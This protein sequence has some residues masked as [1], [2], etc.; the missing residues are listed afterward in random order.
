MDILSPLAYDWFRS[1]HRTKYKLVEGKT[2]MRRKLLILRERGF[3]FFC[4]VAK[5]VAH[6]PETA[7]GYIK[8]SLP[9]IRANTEG[10]RAITE[11]D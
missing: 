6:K 1:G 3:I 9:G 4:Q 11:R 7:R 8:K 5:L 10:S 2:S